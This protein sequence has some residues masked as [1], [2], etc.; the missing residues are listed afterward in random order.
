MA[1]RDEQVGGSHYRLLKHQPLDIIEGRYGRIGKE[2]ALMNLT[3]KYLLRRK[4][5]VPRELDLEKALDCVERLIELEAE[6]AK[7][8]T[9]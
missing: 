1:K 4:E 5:E 6:R 7:E 9:R 3:L 8:N 2:A